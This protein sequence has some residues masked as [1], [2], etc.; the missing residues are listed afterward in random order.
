ME[1]WKI[2]NGTQSRYEVSSYGRVRSVDRVVEYSD[3]RKVAYKG[4]MLRLHPDKDGYLMVT[5]RNN[6]RHQVLKTHRLVANAFIPNSNYLPEVNHINGKKDDNRVE[7][8]EWVTSSQNKIHAVR[9]GISHPE[10]NCRPKKG[11]ECYQSKIL[12]AYKDGIEVK[13]WCPICEAQKDGIRLG[14]L[15]RQIKKGRPYKGMIFKKVNK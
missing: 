9:I 13:R 8:L 1:V 14:T 7:N 5:I 3:G 15:F 6:G 12:I 4:R 2:I 11:S 10:R